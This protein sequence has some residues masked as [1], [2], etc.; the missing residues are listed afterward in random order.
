MFRVTLLHRHYNDALIKGAVIHP[1]KYCS[2]ILL[3]KRSQSLVQQQL[4]IGWYIGPKDLF[5]NWYYSTYV[6]S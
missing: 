4:K 5:L 1:T 6:K 2:L 3:H